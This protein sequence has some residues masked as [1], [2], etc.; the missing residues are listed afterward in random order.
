MKRCIFSLLIITIISLGYGLPIISSNSMEIKTNTTDATIMSSTSGDITFP[1]G[2]GLHIGGDNHWNLTDLLDVNQTL[3]NL[4][5][6]VGDGMTAYTGD[7]LIPGVSENRHLVAVELINSTI[8]NDNDFGEGE[9]YFNITVN[10]NFTK[11]ANYAANDGDTLLLNLSVFYSWCF[12]LS[13]SVEVWEDD[14]APTP[15]DEL[16]VYT[17][18]TNSPTSEVITGN[19]TIG[20]AQVWLNITVFDTK[21]GIT[22]E[23]LAEGTKPYFY[24]SDET[25]ATEDPDEVYARVIIGP[26]DDAGLATAICI[27]YIFYWTQ[28]NF[29]IPTD[30]KFHDDDY[31]EFLIFIDPNNLMT[32][33]R[34]VLDDG[35]YV[36]NMNSQRIAIW[37]EHETT[38]ILETAAYSSDELAPLIGDN[39]SAAYKY[40]NITER[41]DAFRLALSG[42]RTMNLLVQTSFHNFQEGPPGV[43]DIVS[44]EMGFNYTINEFNDT[45]IRKFF[46]R[47]YTAFEQGLWFI[48]AVG[49]ETPKVHPFTF[50]IVNP[51]KFPYLTNGYPNVVD[52]IAAFQKAN[53][54]WVN[55]EYEIDL[56]LALLLKARYTITS[57]DEVSPGDEF[58]A[59][60]SVEILDDQTEIALLYDL[61][62]NGSIQALFF[63]RNFLLDQEGKVSVNIPV[64]TMRLILTLLGY[65]PYQKS[66]LNLDKSGYL[67]LDNFQLSTNLLGDILTGNM[68]L[69]IWDLIKGELPHYFPITASPLHL[70]D[71]FMEAIDINLG[72]VFSGF[73]NGTIRTDKTSLATSGKT[74][75]KFDGTTM[76]TTTHIV[77]SSDVTDTDT[78]QIVLDDLLFAY[79]FLADWSLDIDFGTILSLIAPQYATMHFNIGTFPNVGFSSD[80]SLIESQSTVSKTTTI[81]MDATSPSP[82]TS[83]NAIS[84]PAVTL[85]LF[86]AISL[87]ITRNKIKK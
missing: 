28:E 17:Y 45:I 46:R 79:Q 61:Y 26:D 83:P 52:D 2:K 81:T 51:F 67:T 58:D 66:G 29:P 11:T 86:L 25:S 36:S 16:G 15:D 65:Q 57:P 30:I 5:D 68:S 13:I 64:R 41:P 60:I 19:T 84:L 85:I 34:Y 9:I 71:Y 72:A 48:S 24:F 12:A 63:D 22:A 37:E 82:N 59:T 44:S 74:S 18:F 69:H 53:K 73:V 1:F 7:D 6:F 32:P 42:I 87:I 8:W 33:Y 49:I 14:P 76:S 50:D 3:E 31:E 77:T 56:T 39:Y 21:T 54:S 10:G 4:P 20:D 27:Q 40:F 62:V 23:S 78:F 43:F 38:D 35:S 47:H 80:D 75:F 70:I 55:Y